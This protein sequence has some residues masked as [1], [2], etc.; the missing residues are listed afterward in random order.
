VLFQR[1][2]TTALILNDL[3]RIP[4]LRL[5]RPAKSRNGSA[6]RKRSKGSTGTPMRIVRA[7]LGKSCNS[8]ADSYHYFRIYRSPAICFSDFVAVCRGLHPE[9]KET[10]TQRSKED[11]R[12]GYDF[13]CAVPKSVSLYLALTERQY[14]HVADRFVFLDD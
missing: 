14:E 11:R 6:P 4:F 12:P 3:Q 9:T 13:C 5:S 1:A 10:L 2:M 7:E 8:S